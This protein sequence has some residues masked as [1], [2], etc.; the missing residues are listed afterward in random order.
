MN[1][2]EELYFPNDIPDQLDLKVSRKLSKHTF[3]LPSCKI[4]YLINLISKQTQFTLLFTYLL[5]T[6]SFLFFFSS[7]S[8]QEILNLGKEILDET[9]QSSDECAIRLFYTSRNIFEM[10]AGLIPEYHKKFLETIPQQV[11]KKLLK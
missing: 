10:Y 7:K 5:D 8:A 6:L 9:C 3:Q 2:Q 11:G 4:R 1:F